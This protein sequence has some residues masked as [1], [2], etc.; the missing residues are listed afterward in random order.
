M[1]SV[2][3]ALKSKTVWTIII[4]FLLGGTEALSGVIPDEV[5]TQVLFVLGVLATLF[6]LNPGQKYD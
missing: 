4:M 6:K 5:Q 2:F 3:K 1:Q